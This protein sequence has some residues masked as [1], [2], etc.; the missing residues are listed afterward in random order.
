MVTS[1]LILVHSR[2]NH[3]LSFS[4]MVSSPVLPSLTL[5]N[6]CLSSITA[7]DMLFPVQSNALLGPLAHYYSQMQS[8]LNDGQSMI[9]ALHQSHPASTSRASITSETDTSPDLEIIDEQPDMMDLRIETKKIQDSNFRSVSP[10]TG[11]TLSLS[12]ESYLKALAAGGAAGEALFHD[13]G[14]RSVSPQQ[15]RL[16]DYSISSI[17]Q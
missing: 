6:P 15:R 17:M 11:R 16:K 5:I 3:H 9:G 4:T 13:L 12:P 14:P 1:Q 7:S 10:P 2:L 8:A